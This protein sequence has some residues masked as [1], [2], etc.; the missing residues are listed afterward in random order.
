MALGVA[1]FALA[2]LMA[3][4]PIGLRTAQES[5]NQT[6][7]ASIAQQIRGELQQISFNSASG[8]YNIDALSGL[9]N[10]YTLDGIK[11]VATDPDAYYVAT[12]SVKSVSAAGA[13]FD[14]ANARAVTVTLAYPKVAPAAAQKKIVFSLFSA[15]QP[16]MN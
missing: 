1:S 3:L 6:V 13:V 12:F 7:A 2:S 4:L 9:V 14:T 5:M 10:Y 8:P 15:R 11:T 16:S